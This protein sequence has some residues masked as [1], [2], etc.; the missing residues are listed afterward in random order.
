MSSE[1]CSNSRRTTYSFLSNSIPFSQPSGFLRKHWRIAGMQSLARS[2]RISGWTGTFL[3]PSTD[4]PSFA[5][6]TSK[7]LFAN[8]RIRRSSGRKNMP[9][10]YSP[11]SPIERPASFAAFLKNEC[12]IPTRIPTPSPTVPLASFPARCSSFSTMASASS[13]TEYSGTPS[14]L[15]TAP[16]PQASCSLNNESPCLIPYLLPRPAVFPN[17]KAAEPLMPS[18]IRDS[19]ASSKHNNLYRYVCQQEIFLLLFRQMLLPPFYCWTWTPF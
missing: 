2:P 3:Q 18:Y 17:K 15:T 8:V 10:P 12:A 1:L 5:A 11:A 4:M 6:I 13:M 14:I 19:V 9:I 16:M 7:S